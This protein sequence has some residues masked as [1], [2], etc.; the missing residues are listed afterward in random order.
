M[1]YEKAGGHNTKTHVTLQ[2]SPCQPGVRCRLPRMLADYVRVLWWKETKANFNQK[3]CILEIFESHTIHGKCEETD[4]D[5]GRVQVIYRFQE[6][7]VQ[8]Q[9]IMFVQGVTA[10]DESM[11]IVFIVFV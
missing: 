1:L 4:L 3:K 5:I 9:Q 8:K 10:G 7:D 2:V 6:K 11:S